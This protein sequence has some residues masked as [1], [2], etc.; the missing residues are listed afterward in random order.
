MAIRQLQNGL[1]HLRALPSPEQIEQRTQ[2]LTDHHTVLLSEHCPLRLLR[3]IFRKNATE[4]TAHESAEIKTL[5]RQHLRLGFVLNRPEILLAL[6]LVTI[7][8]VA[9][10]ARLVVNRKDRTSLVNYVEELSL[11]RYLLGTS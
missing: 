3:R 6:G 7:L 9:A 4:Q 1:A 8:L 2:R 10:D 5:V 11:R